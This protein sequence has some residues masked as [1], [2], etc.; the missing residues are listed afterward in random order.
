MS[1]VLM[2]NENTGDVRA[3]KANG[4]LHCK[5]KCEKSISG[6][7]FPSLHH[8]IN[9]TRTLMFLGTF[10]LGTYGQNI[11]GGHHKKSLPAEQ[12]K[13]ELILIPPHS[14]VWFDRKRNLFNIN[15]YLHQQSIADV[16]RQYLQQKNTAG[17]HPC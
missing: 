7:V 11:I 4:F 6:F 9:T 15:P 13:E 1:N 5:P 12:S 16:K 8:R 2:K 14:A 17:G 3:Y 10:C